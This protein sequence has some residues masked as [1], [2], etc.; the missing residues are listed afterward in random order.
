[1]PKF[2]KNI[3]NKTALILVMFKHNL[4]ILGFIIFELDLNK[5]KV[6]VEDIWRGFDLLNLEMLIELDF[7]K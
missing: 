5:I 6:E 3:I 2:L 7:D 4:K 1:M